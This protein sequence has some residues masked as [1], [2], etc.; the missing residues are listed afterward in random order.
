[1]LPKI[2]LRRFLETF[3]IYSIL[4]GVVL[5]FMGRDGMHLSLATTDNRE[6]V[7]EIDWF[8]IY[9]DVRHSTSCINNKFVYTSRGWF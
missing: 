7:I 6:T 2:N 9:P 4:K 1:M 3:E 8:I 5:K